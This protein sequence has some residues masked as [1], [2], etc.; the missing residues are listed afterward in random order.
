MEDAS[1]TKED[2]LELNK[3]VLAN[4]PEIY[5]MA[6]AFEPYFLE[7]DKL[8]FAPYHYRSGGRIGFSMLG[9]PAYRYFYMDW[10]QI[11]KEL[12]RAVWTEPY[13]DEGGGN[14]IMATYTVPFY[15]T[16]DG[17][18][19]FAGVVTA[20]ISLEWL[21]DMISDIKLFKTGYAFLLSRHGT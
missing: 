14:I 5:G 15:R 6:I 18:K 11:P 16:M 12:E 4:N 13:N 1:L 17:K 19:V 3:R 9:D 7:S 2:I 21:E 8:Y 20:D 10:Y